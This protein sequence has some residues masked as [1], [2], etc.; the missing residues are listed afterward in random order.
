[1]IK[2]REAQQTGE[3][4]DLDPK[5]LAYCLIGISNFIGLKWVIFDNEPVPDEVIREIMRFIRSGAFADPQ[6][7]N[8]Q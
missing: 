5:I 7:A 3:F 6:P 1:M 8:R 4:L 2:I